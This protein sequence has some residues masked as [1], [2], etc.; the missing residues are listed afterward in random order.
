M[1][2]VESLVDLVGPSGGPSG[3]R[4]SSVGIVGIVRM[5]GLLE[6]RETLNLFGF[7]ISSSPKVTSAHSYSLET[8]LL[9][10]NSA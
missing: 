1:L 2:L 10:F 8:H 5:A 9:C 3:S 6:P 7:R 4:V